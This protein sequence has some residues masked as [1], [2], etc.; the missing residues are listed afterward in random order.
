MLERTDQGFRPEPETWLRSFQSVPE[1]VWKIPLPRRWWINV[2]LFCLTLLTSTAFG[3]ALTQSFAAGRPLDADLVFTGYLLIAHGDPRVWSGLQ[4][5]APLL[6]ILLAHEFGHYFECLRWNVDGSL[7]YFLPSP[8]LFGTL[9]AFIRIRSP[10]YTRKG[11]FDIGISG[12]IAGFVAL[13]PVLIVGIAESRVM[14]RMATHGPF[15]FGT[16]LLMSLV[17]RLFF[18]GVASSSI[19][20]SPVAMAAWGGLLATAFNLFPLGQLDGGHILYA[21]CGERVHRI[22][23]TCFVVVLGVLGFFYWAWWIWAVLMLFFGRRHPLVYDQTPLAS[24]RIA[25]SLVALLIFILS[26]SV[27]P[28]RTL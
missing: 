28:V 19:L 23:S 13:L 21:V 9:G 25:L 24:K 17:E 14:P 18:H 16:P 6:L 1:R 22:A 27:V 11:L 10:I 26:I 15:V 20:L 2:L 12:P 4:F 5:S 8:T 7:P 3:F